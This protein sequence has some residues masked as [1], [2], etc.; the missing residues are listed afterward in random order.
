[1]KNLIK[2]KIKNIIRLIRQSKNILINSAP[3]YTDRNEGIRLHLGSGKINLQGWINIDVEDKK[4]IHIKEKDFKLECFTDKSISEI[5]LCHVLEHFTENEIS[6]LMDIFS[7]KLKKGGILRISVPNF[8]NILEIY[9]KNKNNIEK[10]HPILFG[11]QDNLYNYH[12]SAFNKQ[13]LISILKT[14]NFKKIHEWDTLKIFGSSL[15]DYS[16]SKIKI[17][18]TEIPISLNI[19]GEKKS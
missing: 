5:Y 14:N 1:M 17:G 18:R 4:H 7:K 6:N 12:K 2:E 19:C 11:G 13:K 15:G 8:D 3:I 16:N 10:I 9:K